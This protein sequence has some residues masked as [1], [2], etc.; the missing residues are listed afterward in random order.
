MTIQFAA[1]EREEWIHSAV[2][3]VR[4]TPDPDRSWPPETLGA[5]G[6]PGQ[7]MFPSSPRSWK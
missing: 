7:T 3:A 1:G 5:K 6:T 4:A 2:Q